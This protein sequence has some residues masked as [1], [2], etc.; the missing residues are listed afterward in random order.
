MWFDGEKSRGPVRRNN[1]QSRRCHE[2]WPLNRHTKS[3]RARGHTPPANIETQRQRQPPTMPSMHI[4]QLRRSPD[5]QIAGAR[6][7][8]GWHM[9]KNRKQRLHVYIGHRIKTPTIRHHTR[10]NDGRSSTSS[11]RCAQRRT[12]SPAVTC[13]E[14]AQPHQAASFR[15]TV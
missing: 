6:T 11:D 1:A 4:W 3:L 12:P 13:Q 8:Q 7:C 9:Y 2:R 10:V 14:K 15:C 5:I